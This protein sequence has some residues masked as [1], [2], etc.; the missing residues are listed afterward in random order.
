VTIQPSNPLEAG[1]PKRLFAAR[2]PVNP[3][4]DQFAVTGDGQKFLVIE[5]VDA[6]EAKPFTIVLNWPATS[7]N[8]VQ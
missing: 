3:Q 2:T 8:M 7:R 5:S 1:I 4:L 6:V